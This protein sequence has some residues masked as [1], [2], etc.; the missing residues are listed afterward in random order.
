M[1]RSLVQDR[2]E[3]TADAV[4]ALTVE[5]CLAHLP[6]VVQSDQYSTQDICRV[7]VQAAANG[8]T[9]EATSAALQAAPCASTV[10]H[11]LQAGLLQPMTEA[12]LEDAL[13]ALLVA[14]LPG[15]LLARPRRVAIDLVLIPY[16]GEPDQTPDELRYSAA[17]QGTT[18]F[19]AYATAYVI[20]QHKRVT[21]ALT[22]VHAHETMEAI[23]KRLL[24]RLAE[25]GLPLCRLYLDRGFYTVAVIRFL[26]T[27]AFASVIPAKVA[28]QQLKALCQTRKSYRT[29]YTL[30]SS[31]LGDEA[32]DLWIVVSYHQKRGGKRRRYRQPYVVIGD[33]QRPVPAVQEEHGR[34]FGIEASY[35]LL[36]QAR[37]NT[38]SRDPKYRLLLVGLALTLINLWITVLWA[39]LAVPRRGGRWLKRR[40]LTLA[41]FLALLAQAVQGLYGFVNRIRRPA[42]A[43]SPG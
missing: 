7:L 16:Y 33:L 18:R 13:N 41:H 15:G 43:A 10:R 31:S 36:N 17:R 3:L 37:A 35:R 1:S 24:A 9:I 19:H 32:V 29:P 25:L 34:R 2:P 14:Q 42:P 20:R 39:V 38:T 12:H 26:K 4:L 21:V 27:Q 22:S 23:L 8:A 28:G 40:L 5:T 6:L 11:H 30:H